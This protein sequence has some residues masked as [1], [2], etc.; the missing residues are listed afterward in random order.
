V[1][2]Q[3]LTT[4]LEALGAGPGL[5]SPTM[6]AVI[7]QLT[8]G[9][10]GDDAEFIAEG[11]RRA[12]SHLTP[13]PVRVTVGGHFSSGKSS[14]I[15]M[16]IG[17]PLLPTDELPETGVP[18]LLQS[19]EA[20]QVLMRTRRGV[21][22][23]PFSTQAI[24]KYVS[25]IGADGAYRDSIRAVRDLRIIL[26]NR[27]IPADATW[28]DSPGINDVTLTDVAAGL[29]RDGDVLVWVVKSHQAL[30]MT[31]QEFLAAHIA[32]AG[33]ASVAFIVNAFLDSDTPHG[34]EAF[35]ARQSRYVSRIT[36][37]IDTGGLPARVAVTSARA[38]AAHPDGFGGPEARALLASV[39]DPAAPLVTATRMF[40]ATTEL[41]G[42]MEKLSARVAAE[43]QRVAAEDSKIAAQQQARAR[44]HDE[45]LRAVRQEIATLL[46]SHRSTADDCAA[47]VIRKLMRGSSPKP[48]N[49]YETRLNAKLRSAMNRISRGATKKVNQ[50]ARAHGHTRLDSRGGNAIASALEPRAVRIAGYSSGSGFLQAVGDLFTGKKKQ[51]EAMRSQLS[52]AGADATARMLAATEQIVAEAA[53]YCTLQAPP[54]PQVNRTRL[55]ALRSARLT[56]E[57][58]VAEPLRRALAAAQEQA[59][60]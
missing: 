15:N 60:G 13:A 16:L 32:E 35:T 6:G 20:N 11:L 50:C 31:E 57:T 58:D 38:A 14:L 26:G 55:N 23:I 4:T 9:L 27:P 7:Q 1:N 37:N 59:G 30:A 40:R 34:W 29:A 8:R 25:L 12:A 45:F 19:G 41:R 33:P 53:Q 43:E 3:E 5:G 39:S 54:L 51:R 56:L 28:V 36:Q 24:S 47:Q 42:V 17:T 21:K 52:Q 49:Y 10:G 18:C 48:P 2:A 22:K 44:Q 46:S